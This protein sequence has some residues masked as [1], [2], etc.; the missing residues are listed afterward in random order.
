MTARQSVIAFY[1][2][3]VAIVAGGGMLLFYNFH[4]LSQNTEPVIAVTRSGLR[5]YRD[6]SAA[7]SEAEKTGK[8]LFI[9]FGALWC[10][11]CLQ[12]NEKMDKDPALQTALSGAVL[13]RI[14][15]TDPTFESYTSRKGY[16]AL[17]DGLPFFVIE[18]RGEI[19]LASHEWKNTAAIA[20]AIKDR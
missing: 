13:V 20:R 10:E 8:P 9:E 12:F 16:E 6:E 15:D 7:R 18:S 11:P 14:M 5:F 1:V 19:R 2:A 4:T 17:A 3:L